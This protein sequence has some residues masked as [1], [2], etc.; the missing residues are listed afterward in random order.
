MAFEQ[1]QALMQLLKP[2]YG[3]QQQQY[4]PLQRQQQGPM[5]HMQSAPSQKGW[6]GNLMETLFGQ[7]PQY[8]YSSDYTPYQRQGF[9]DLFNQG[10]QNL[11]DPYAGFGDIENYA[12]DFYQNQL[13]PGVANRF[14]NMGGGALS[15][16]D[17]AK[18]LGAAGTGLASQ[19]AQH[20]IGYGQ[21]NRQFGLQQAQ[22]GLTPQYQSFQTPAT[23]GVLGG[24][25]GAAPQLANTGIRYGLMRGL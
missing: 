22:L 5:M 17:F 20:K 9:Q 25:L 11:N 1:N 21:Q 16:P 3:I 10:M 18:Q 2:G 8:G 6:W 4:N 19:L 14:T 23:G 7:D 24:L 13:V 12:K 15:S